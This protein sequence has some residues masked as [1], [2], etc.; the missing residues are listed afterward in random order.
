MLHLY[1]RLFPLLALGQSPGCI[2][3]TPFDD[4][5]PPLH[6]SSHLTSCHYVTPPTPLSLQGTEQQLERLLSQLQ[7]ALTS[8]ELG[9]ECLEGF[10]FLYCL[11][12]Y[13][14]CG[15]EVGGVFE[16]SVG[17]PCEGDCEQVIS[18]D[19]GTQEWGYL[20]NIVGQLRVAEVLDLPALMSLVECGETD[21]GGGACLTLS[22]G[23][24]VVM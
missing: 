20:T 10:L 4:P 18:G 14:V 16:S 22:Q 3:Y 21:G 2:Q 8:G 9:R 15:Q 17:V 23:T 24:M 13:S 11:Q 19:C 6:C 7:P 5:A 1:C 12:A